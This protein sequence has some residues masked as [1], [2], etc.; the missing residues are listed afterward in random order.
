MR[1][2]WNKSKPEQL[3]LLHGL[4]AEPN[5][6]LLN[7]GSDAGR[8]G[9]VDPPLALPSDPSVAQATAG[10]PLIVS[11]EL[12]DEDAGNPRTEFPEAELK[13]LADD[14][15]QHGILEPIV[16]QPPGEA[17]RYHIHFGAKRLRAAKRAGLLEVPVVLRTAAPDPHA[18]CREPETSRPDAP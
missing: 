15:R 7:A 2:P 10:L 14:V 5:T 1:M 13:E 16:V 6:T 18:G 11:V 8:V 12:L 17:G 3:D 9:P 4:T